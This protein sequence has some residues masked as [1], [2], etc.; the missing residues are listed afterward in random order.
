MEKRININ[1]VEPQAYK[2]MYALEGYLATTQLSKTHKELIKIRASQINGCAFCIDMHTKDALKNGETHQ[3]IFLLN[4][5]RETDL[6]SEEEKLILA[7]TEE[8]T[9]IHDK[10][11]SSE[12]YKKAEQFFDKNL[13]AQ[14][15]MAIVIINAWNRIAV[16]THLEPAK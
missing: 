10:G 3:R 9:L 12:T 15:I 1:E 16:S 2:A 4:A 14:I 6:F 5:W 7:I 8:I 11:L 13:I